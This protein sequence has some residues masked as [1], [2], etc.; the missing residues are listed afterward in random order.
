MHDD[1]MTITEAEAKAH[2][3]RY[4]RRV[5]AG[6]TIIIRRRNKT[7]AQLVPPPKEQRGKTLKLGICRGQFRV[8]KNFNAR[9]PGFE[10]EFYG[11]CK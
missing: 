11:D 5:E 7:V 10:S 3:E 2:L 1:F 9:L 6:E 4:L 8:P